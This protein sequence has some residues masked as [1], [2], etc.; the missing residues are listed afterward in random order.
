MMLAAFGA[1]GAGAPAARAQSNGISLEISEQVFGVM[2]AL[3]AAGF[4]ADVS[5][6]SEMPARLALRDDLL[7][8]HG[9]A[10]EAV[11]AFYKEHALGDPGET[12]SR[13][14]TFA[15]AIGAPPA[16]EF[17]FRREE[18]P[19][20]VLS[21]EGFQPI[22]ANFY[23][24]AGLE[25]RWATIEPEYLRAVGTDD[26]QLR[27]IVFVTNGYLRELIK[28]TR[29]T[30]TVYVEPLAGNR[31]NFRNFGD[32]YSI[33][34]G[35]GAAFPAEQVQHAYLHYMLDPL[36]L[37]YRKELDKKA[38]LVNT[39]AKAPRLPE[40][41]HS[42]FVAFADECL[43]KAVELRLKKMSAPQLELALSADDQAGFILV[44]PFVRELQKFEK[45]EPAMQFYFPDL[46]AGIDVAEEQ[47]RLKTVTFAPAEETAA[48]ENV[49]AAREKQPSEL[50]AWLAEGD[51]DIAAQ[52]PFGA[53]DVFAKALAKYP[54][55]PR[56]IYGM[57]VAS[58]M[59]KDVDQARENFERIVA[60]A[61]P[62]GTVEG[63][64][65][66]GAA[67][68]A[69]TGDGASSGGG[70][71]AAA[72]VDPRVLAWSHVYLGRIHDIEG[73][74]ELAIGEYRAALAV[75][76]APEAARVAAQRGADAPY[77]PSHGGSAGAGT[78]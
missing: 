68:S 51:R 48:A 78:H 12:L 16:F 60:M 38:E 7:K 59:R 33:V 39:A 69:S 1:L 6:L 56:A 65:A 3:D 8:L 19:P 4:D 21:L 29:R 49:D 34:I 31:A 9:P 43:I 23:R 53:A 28:P 71:D 61:A 54:D 44:R 58:V 17:Q 40:V 35:S 52:D 73:D 63:S 36:P 74:R 50:E 32:H 11:R 26:A 24:E 72:R 70:A 5:T 66:A 2:C 30:F 76:G 18:L 13:Y 77:A 42:D 15:L 20:D 57:A 45:A 37:R 75:E 67:A 22:L 41:Y 62:A 55:E 25:R 64:A 47:K 46:V 14:I 27:R 10:T